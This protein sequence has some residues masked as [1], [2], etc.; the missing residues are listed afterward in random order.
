MAPELLKPRIL[1][2]VVIVLVV[3]CTILLKQRRRPIPKRKIIPPGIPIFGK[4]EDESSRMAV[5]EGYDQVRC[6]YDG[7]EGRLEPDDR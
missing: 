7:K 6:G 1:G 4:E 3:L 2:P 5:K